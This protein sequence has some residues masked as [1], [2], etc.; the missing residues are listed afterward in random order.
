IDLSTEAYIMYDPTRENAWCYA[1]MGGLGNRAQK[2]RKVASQQLVSMLIIVLAKESL[3]EYISEISATYTGVGLLG[4]MGNK[5]CVSVRFRLFDSYICTLSSHLAAFMNQVERRNQDYAEICKRLVFPNVPDDKTDYATS[6]WND[7]GDEGVL[8]IENSNIV[9]NWSQQNSIFHSDHLIWVGDLNYRINLTEPEVKAALQKRDL[10][11]LIEYDQLNIERASGRA[12]RVFNEGEIDFLPTYKYDSGTNRYDTSEKRRAPAWTDRVLWRKARAHLEPH[13]AAG[14]HSDIQLTSYSSCMDLMMS[15]HKPV[16]AIMH[17]KA[18]KIDTEKQ[19]QVKADI[20][21]LVTEHRDDRGPDGRISNSFVEFGDVEFMTQKKVSITLENTGQL[22]ASWHFI[23]K[24]DETVICKHW[25]YISR[26]SG[27]L[28]PGEQTVIDFHINI[29]RVSASAFNNDEDQ[30]DDTLILRLENGKDFFLV[31]SGNYIPSCY[32]MS[33]EKL[34]R[35]K[36]PVRSAGN[37]KSQRDSRSPSPEA[38]QNGTM[39]KEIW[40]MLTFLWNK[41]TL[42]LD[43]LFLETGNLLLTEYIIK[44]LN[45]GDNF[46]SSILMG[47]NEGDKDD[48]EPTT[49]PPAT[50]E[51]PKTDNSP[52]APVNPTIGANS[53]VDALVAFLS[54][55]PEPV[56]PTSLFQRL[57]DGNLKPNVDQLNEHMSAVHHSVLLYLVNFLKDAI[58]YCPENCV[59]KRTHRIVNIFVAALMRPPVN[60]SDRNPKLT[61]RKQ[62]QVIMGLLA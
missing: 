56:I 27:V 38:S 10:K 60:Y 5:G 30:I 15:D 9:R 42:Q 55:L 24:P 7:G 58:K 48:E 37:D 59:E 18:R 1:V 43:G 2:Y 12:F 35:L 31:V 28:G 44:C 6:L 52:K 41:N 50:L 16:N 23:P 57:I 21:K 32:G 4:M 45:T 46:D 62:Q 8:F 26:V 54:V 36:Y 22:V 34:A 11:S 33:L 20:V 25:L 13:A 19:A 14:H 39:P 40:R 53:M 61:R 17:L 51:S 3:T 47:L 29:D 49:A